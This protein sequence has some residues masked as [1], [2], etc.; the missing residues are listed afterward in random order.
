MKKISFFDQNLI[1]VLDLWI[2]D[3]DAF[4]VELAKTTEEEVMEII[5]EI[6]FNLLS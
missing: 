3:L 5:N 2:E 1:T 6:Y 4:L